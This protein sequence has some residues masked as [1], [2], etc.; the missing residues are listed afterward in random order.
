[1]VFKPKRSSM[2]RFTL[3]I[4]L[5]TGLISII[6]VEAQTAGQVELSL[7]QAWEYALKNN[8]TMKNAEIDLQ[9]AQK[10][11]WETTAIGLPQVSASASYQHI[12]KVP[13]MSFGGM[14]LL[15]DH[16]EG[17]T[18]SGVA[19]GNNADSIFLNYFPYDP[20]KLGV[21]D[22]A[23][24]SL[25][26]SQL[27]F[28]GEYLVGLQASKVYYQIS[29]NSLVQATSDIKESVANSYYLV[30]ILERNRDILKQSLEN[31]T[32]TLGEMREMNKQGFIED[33][34]VD[35]IELT[36]HSL[37]N[38]LVSVNNQ[39]SASYDLLKFQLGLPFETAITLT[40]KLE[41]IVGTSDIASIITKQFQVENH[42][43]YKIME[44]Q[45]AA[46]ILN[47]KRQKSGYLPTLA[48]F[49]K[50]T[51]NAQKADFDFTMKDI[52]GLSLNVPIFSSGQRNVQVQQRTL[53]LQ[54]IRNMKTNVAQGLELDFINSRNNLNSAYDK[55]MNE[56]R[57]IE[58]TSRIYNKTLTK[59]KEGVAS[60][61][62]LTTAQNQYLTAQTNY[63]TALYTLL[64]SRNK[65][66]KLLNIQ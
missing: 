11:I 27:I 47:L 40:E 62:D 22:N 49:Y 55:F 41:D 37:E 1:M 20:I 65:L 36:V 60:S 8:A 39:V 17:T 18:L 14:T 2:K 12:F 48:A 44:N 63:F 15:S 34:D 57:N 23:T 3:S 42:I 61:M 51:E 38:G 56:K 6:K 46:G 4:F 53:E 29:Q 7:K 10:K 19:T 30:L 5:L 59:Y 21:K 43:T 26:V 58:L 32:R 31:L 9:L 54:K 13:E 52:A 25:N 50:H 28:S 35:Q 45:E 33:T 16:R 64:S 24:I 66:E